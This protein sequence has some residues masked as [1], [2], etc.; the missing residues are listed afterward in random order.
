MAVSWGPRALGRLVA[1]LYIVEGVATTAF[2]LGA[3]Q[4]FVADDAA[5]T[6]AALL[7][8]EAAVRL[9]VAL[10]LLA[11]PLKLTI[12][13]LLY[14]SFRSPADRY[15]ALL[16]LLV[17]TVAAGAQV[18][19]AMLALGA[20]D[21]AQGEALAAIGSAPQQAIVQTL[22][23]LS[24]LAYDTFLGLFGIWC[25]VI[26]TLAYGS[27]FIPRPVGTAMTLAGA[28]Y[29]IFLFRSLAYAIGRANLVLG[30]GQLV[31][32]GWLLFRGID[33]ERWRAQSSRT[34]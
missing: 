32:L 19:A 23:S 2:Q 21:A 29:S 26:G 34:D 30:A 4:H 3:V 33:E 25:V 31:F 7:A 22:M 12:A 20:L 27:T 28:G 10:G 11:V 6:A 16:Q 8:N 13:I 14:R 5:A 18:T 1:V 9:V 24:A 15:M 17:M